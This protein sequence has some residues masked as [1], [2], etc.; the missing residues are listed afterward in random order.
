M[1]RQPS[2]SVEVL[3]G[4]GIQVDVTVYLSSDKVIELYEEEMDGY[5]LMNCGGRVDGEHKICT[6]CLL[7]ELNDYGPEITKD[8]RDIFGG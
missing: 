6:T 3:V 7:N 5:C 2:E 1:N 4:G 8:L